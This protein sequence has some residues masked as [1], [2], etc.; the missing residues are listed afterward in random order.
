M[1]TPSESHWPNQ[2]WEPRREDALRFLS[3]HETR[4]FSRTEH[5]SQSYNVHTRR[6]GVLFRIWLFSKRP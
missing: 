1:L 4:T 6:R 5:L 3:F 2:V